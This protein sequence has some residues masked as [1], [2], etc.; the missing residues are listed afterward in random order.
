MLYVQVQ[1]YASPEET[2]T[3]P[4][5]GYLNVSKETF[6]TVLAGSLLMLPYMIILL[7]GSIAE[8]EWLYSTRL[9]CAITALTV[10][11]SRLVFLEVFTFWT[12]P[13]G[14]YV[15]VIDM[16]FTYLLA[17]GVVSVLEGLTR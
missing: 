1:L 15:S 4:Q 17:E 12:S 8:A 3:F 2:I 6:V 5:L 16:A 7:I 13:A 9:Y 14:E 10:E 11:I